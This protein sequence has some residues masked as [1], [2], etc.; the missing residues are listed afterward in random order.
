MIG[1]EVWHYPDGRVVVCPEC[2]GE[3]FKAVGYT[4]HTER[5]KQIECLDCGHQ[6]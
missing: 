5:E 1:T 3:K 4:D 2:G 6:F